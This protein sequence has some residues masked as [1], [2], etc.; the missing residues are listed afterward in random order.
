MKK[1]FKLYKDALSVL[2]DLSDE[3]AGQLFKAICAYQNGEEIELN[4]I[5]KI[6]FSPLKA[7]FGR[8]DEAYQVVCERNQKNV[9]K[10]WST[11]DTTGNDSIPSDTKH[12]DKDKD[13]KIYIA[14][15]TRAIILHLNA[16]AGTKYKTNTKSTQSL[17]QARLNE[18]YTVN[19]FMTVHEVKTKEWA[20]TDMAKFLRPETLYSNKFESYLNQRQGDAVQEGKYKW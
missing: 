18:N 9:K 10:R 8:D 5:V 13:K 20:N 3:Q 17:I 12:T 4:G 6:A 11:K 14:E 2:E 15:Q 19:D 1:S 7:Q 16:T